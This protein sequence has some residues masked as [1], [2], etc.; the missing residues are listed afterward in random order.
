VPAAGPTLRR[1]ELG[2]AL[3]ALR[4]EKGWTVEQVAGRLLC[5]PSKVSRIETGQ[6]G[7]SARDIRDLCDLYEVA[8][9]KERDRLATLAR[10]AR[11]PTWWQDRGLPSSPYYGLEADAAS[12]RDCGIG[13]V[14]GLLQSTDYARAVIRAASVNL[15][16]EEV[17]L[18]VQQR[19]ARQQLLDSDRPPRF[20]AVIDEAILHRVVGSSAI[21]QA[22]LQQ[23]LEISSRPNV[24]VQVLPYDAGAMP[25]GPNKFIILG[26]ETSAVPDVVFIENLTGDIFLDRE[27]DV[28][29]YRI[30][31]AQMSERAASPTRTR[32]MLAAM[33][34][35]Y[36]SRAADALQ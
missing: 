4:A 11:Q 27:E 36:R 21:M 2:A 6:R 34:D 17:E 5:S 32:D 31:F 22:Q 1:R 20:H 33:T 15:T 7:A 26:F 16:V 8:D 30:A 10:E 12:I 25:V 13:V 23:L 29:L 9:R 3:R 28:E 14:P 35:I 24:K 19:M 18:R